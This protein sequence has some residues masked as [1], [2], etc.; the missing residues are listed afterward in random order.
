MAHA[1]Y[2]TDDEVKL[3]IKRG[4]S[5]SHCPE[6]NLYLKSGCCNV[7][8]L[9]DAGVKIGLGT[10]VSGGANPSIISAMRHSIST[11]INLSFTEENYKPLNYSEVFYLATLGGAEGL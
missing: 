5:I 6:S 2:L 9:I 1:I 8:K 3:F 4:S 11:S 7:R 10:D